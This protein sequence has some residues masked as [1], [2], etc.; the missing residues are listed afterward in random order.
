MKIKKI[1]INPKLEGKVLI[2]LE[3]KIKNKNIRCIIEDKRKKEIKYNF[4]CISNYK[5]YINFFYYF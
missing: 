4:I 5:Y 2:T 3:T 1:W